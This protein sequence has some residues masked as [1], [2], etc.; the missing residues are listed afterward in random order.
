MEPIQGIGVWICDCGGTL[1][2]RLHVE[3]ILRNLGDLPEVAW[4]KCH[5]AL[6]R[7]EGLE[8]WK[9]AVGGHT[10][11]GVVIGACSPALHEETFRTASKEAGLNPY[12]L[13]MANIR[14][15]CAW[16]HSDPAVATQK[17]VHLIRRALHRATLQEPVEQREIP[18]EERVLVIG[19]GLAGLEATCALV[20]LGR[21]VTL[22]EREDRLGGHLNEIFYLYEDATSPAEWVASREQTI[23]NHPD[24]EIWTQ[25]E[26]ADLKGHVGHFRATLKG[27]HG[28]RKKNFGA[29]IVATGFHVVSPLP[30][31]DGSE[32]VTTLLGLQRMVDL[33]GRIG[34]V[35]D[36]SGGDPAV[37][38]GS[39]LCTAMRIRERFGSEVCLLCQ[40]MRVSTDDVEKLYGQAQDRG[41][42]LFKY[43]EKPQF[44]VGDEGVECTFSD[45]LLKSEIRLNVDL[46]AFSEQI[47]PS[48]GTEGLADMLDLH[49]GPKGYV[50]DDE[51]WV[52]PVRSNRRGI[53]LAGGCRGPADTLSVLMDARAAAEQA[54]QV[55]SGGKL[56]LDRNKA[57]ID[58]D[59]CVFCLACIRTCPVGAIRPDY[60]QEGAAEIV[61]EACEACGICAAEC[62][63]K[64]I[65][66]T[67]FTDEQMLTEVA[68]A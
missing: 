32:R 58:P 36:G 11:D 5:T 13:A 9:T 8:A 46:V 30:E 27:K 43:E 3:A 55:L 34:I 4:V 14:E 16:V 10:V 59:K 68:F 37:I 38:T 1:A 62:P 7:P 41:V 47:G 57:I 64:A 23:R 56:V 39:A 60:T 45:V 67:G 61:E 31:W 49:L 53:F 50:Q 22:I 44:T 35:L 65:Q 48:L 52:L 20:Q 42:L 24:V 28:Q 66:L 15:Q 17:A 21:P 25:T 40:N 12:V 29:I 33:P 18:V 51:V 26:I 63:A 19:G 54:D 6:C 2:D